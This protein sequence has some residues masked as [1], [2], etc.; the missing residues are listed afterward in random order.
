MTRAGA[1]E[2]GW[3]D[4]AELAFGEV[5]GVDSEDEEDVSP[6]DIEEDPDDLPQDELVACRIAA[7]VD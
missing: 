6:G 2:A 5:E 4:A 1:E 7:T 3:P